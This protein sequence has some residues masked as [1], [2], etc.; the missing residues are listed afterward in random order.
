MMPEDDTTASRG[1]E[2]DEEK[3]MEDCRDAG[4]D[5]A[6][7]DGSDEESIE[8]GAINDEEDMSL[9]RKVDIDN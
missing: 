8:L 6:N 9:I 1:G 4:R 3:G 5:T 7:D 2:E